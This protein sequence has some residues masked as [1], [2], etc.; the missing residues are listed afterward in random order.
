MTKEERAKPKAGAAFA[1]RVLSAA[2]AILAVF[3]ILLCAALAI[4][5]AAGLEAYVVA[6]GSMEPAIPV[7][8]IVYSKAVDPALLDKGDVIVFRDDS[9]GTAPITH[10]VVRNDTAS[11]T[12]VT[13]GDANANID[14][15]S[16]EYSDVIGRVAMHVP[17]IGPVMYWFS[18]V[19]GKV[20]LFL[21]LAE[22]WLLIEVGRRLRRRG[23][24]CV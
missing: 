22:A 5:K 23:P 17:H 24:D 18:S 16:A 6:S 19:L 9:R 1:G 8:S 10:R 21:L 14:P 4:P 7:G 20:V 15:R 3:T 2:G 12:L 13:K 11:G